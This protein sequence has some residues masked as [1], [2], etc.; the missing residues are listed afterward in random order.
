MTFRRLRRARRDGRNG[1]DGLHVALQLGEIEVVE[2][3]APGLRGVE[4]PPDRHEIRN[5]VPYPFGQRN[6]AAVDDD[7]RREAAVRIA[8]AER[9][10]TRKIVPA[11]DGVRQPCRRLM[12]KFR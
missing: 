6:A 5:G 10:R 8:E 11:V 4:F 7:R 9:K 2:H 12:V 1:W 3:F